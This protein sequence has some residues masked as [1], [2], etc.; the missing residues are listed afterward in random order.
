[1]CEMLP[2]LLYLAQPVPLALTVIQ[3]PSIRD[4]PEAGTPSRTA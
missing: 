3:I 1:M 2:Y 4:R